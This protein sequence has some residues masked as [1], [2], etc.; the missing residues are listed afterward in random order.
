M[1]NRLSLSGVA[2]KDRNFAMDIMRGI[3]VLGILLMNIPAFSIHEF[4][5]FWGD[6]IAGKLTTNGFIYKSAVLLGDGRMRGLFTLLFGAGLMLF[7]EN[8][9]T[10]SIAVADAYFRRMMWLMLFG[11]IDSY[12]LLWTGDVLFEYSLCGIFIY[13]FR[14][15]RVRYMFI[16]AFLSLGIYSYI[17]GMAFSENKEKALEYKRVEA[18][19]QQG[20]PVKEEEK[21][22]HDEWA[23]NVLG[24]HYPFSDTCMKQINKDIAETEQTHRGTYL[25]ILKVHGEETYEY[26]SK[27][28][29]SIFGES[30]GTIMLGMALYK[31]GFFSGGLRRRTY[32]IIASLGIVLG[33]ISMAMFMKWQVRSVAELWYC[34]SWRNFSIVYFQQAGRILSTLGYAALIYLFSQMQVLKKFLNLFANV[35]RMALTN[36][37]MQTILCSFYFFGFGLGHYG[38][39]QAKGLLLFVVC[40]WIMQITYSNIYMRY[41]QMGPLEWLWKRLTY[42][43]NFHSSP[44]PETTN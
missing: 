41:F 37:I 29:F 14:N 10:S 16:L 36:Y 32:W 30:F 28:F 6:T 34:Y 18:L 31:L 3:A 23:V 15:V 39:Y 42:G 8:K 5:L 35:G 22:A 40:I 26:H 11:M 7:I 12:L 17:Q 9:R 43:K 4:Y 2:V 21:K 13:A 24:Y 25:D 44:Q 20:K 33:L 19:I 27:V 1:E 38:E